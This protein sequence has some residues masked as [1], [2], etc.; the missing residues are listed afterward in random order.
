MWRVTDTSGAPL[1]GSELA[2][3]SSNS[4]ASSLL[5]LQGR[6]ASKLMWHRTSTMTPWLRNN[7]AS[8]RHLRRAAMW[9]RACSRIIEFASK[10]APTTTRQACFETNLASYKYDATLLSHQCGE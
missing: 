2:R 3:E 4:R 8:N 1:C 9:E 6:H 10:L 7:V 5:R